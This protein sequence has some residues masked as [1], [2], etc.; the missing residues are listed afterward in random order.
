LVS[1]PVSSFLGCNK[2]CQVHITNRR[3]S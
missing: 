2:I 1:P 3:M